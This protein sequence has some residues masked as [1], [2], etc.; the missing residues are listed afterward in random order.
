MTGYTET[1]HTSITE[2]LTAIDNRDPTAVVVISTQEDGTI[3]ID[4]GNLDTSGV[5]AIIQI[6]LLTV[7]EGGKGS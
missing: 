1:N 2:L 4:S 7:H 6:A 5:L 3:N